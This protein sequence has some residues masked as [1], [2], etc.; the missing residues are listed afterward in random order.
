LDG[1]QLGRL[2]K[3]TGTNLAD[4][5]SLS[6]VSFTR[7]ELS[8]CLAKLADQNAPDYQEALAIIRSGKQALARRPRADMPDFKLASQVEIDQQA[9]YEA[10]LKHESEMRSAIT[11]G[12]KEYDGEP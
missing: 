5:G 2:G 7:P 10:Q 12:Q 11:A 8:P 4:R 1:G 6:Q 9:K 3:L